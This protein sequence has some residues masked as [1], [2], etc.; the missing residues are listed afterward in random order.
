MF[1]VLGHL[2]DDDK[3]RALLSCAVVSVQD[4]SKFGSMQLSTGYDMANELRLVVSSSSS[5]KSKGKGLSRYALTL[6]EMSAEEL[7][8][9]SSSSSSSSFYHEQINEWLIKVQK[10]EVMKM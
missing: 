7:S 5:S 8:S 6:Q 1:Q 2:C 9:S 10:G 4:R 3:W